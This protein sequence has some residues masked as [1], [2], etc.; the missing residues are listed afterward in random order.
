MKRRSLDTE[1]VH[2]GVPSP[3][4]E[5]AVTSPIFCSA[6]FEYAG[7]TDY[8]DLKYIRLNNTPNHR[9]LHTKLARIEGGEAALVTGSG[10]AAISVSLMS[11]LEP[12]AHFLVQDG[13][14]GGTH[15]L[16]THDL[17]RWGVEYSFVDGADAGSWEAALRPN[18]RAFYV[19]SMSNPMVHVGDLEA[20][21]E[22]CRKH[23]LVS[24]I[25]NTFATP[26]NFRPIEHGFDVVLHSATKYLN[27]HSD[28]VA[29]AI[30]SSAERVSKALHLL[31]HLGATLDPHACF[32]LTR[33]MKT[34]ALRMERQNSNAL[35][36]A[37]ALEN[38]PQVEQVHYPGLE[39]HPHHHRA[40]RLFKGFGGVLSFQYKGDPKAFFQQLALPVVAPSLGGVETLVTLPC[41]TSHAG[42]SPQER[43]ELGITE[44]LIRV[45]VG[46]EAPQD[47]IEDFLQALS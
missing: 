29:G 8:N 23:S 37:R 9:E 32:L 33:G 42:L 20:T 10:M 24:F 18:T 28:I 21:V 27:G 22:F 6:N 15:T 14:Y 30:V 11:E 2:A 31:N 16:I 5:G 41:N 19:E 36:L 35:A 40:R 25:D 4:I 12:G 7:E 3:R 26:V 1:L 43:E 38:H 46:I 17:K 13:L 47:L 44:Q 39:A 34:L 45:A